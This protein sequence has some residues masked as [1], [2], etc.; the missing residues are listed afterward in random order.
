MIQLY[1]LILILKRRGKRMIKIKPLLQIQIQTLTKSPQVGGFQVALTQ[2]LRTKRKPNAKKM[3]NP[4]GAR[5][6]QCLLSHF[7]L[8]NNYCHLTLL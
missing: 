3:M 6:H 2:K 5:Y 8:E 7:K 4:R 1:I